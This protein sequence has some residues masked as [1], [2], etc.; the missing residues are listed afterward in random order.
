MFVGLI[1]GKPGRYAYIYDS[2]ILDYI[3]KR[4]P[5]TTRVLG[6]LFKKSGYG[7]AFRKNSP[8]VEMFDN[9]ILELRESGMMETI[10]RQWIT[11][12]CPNSESG[13]CKSI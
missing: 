12:S 2:T 4:Q 10:E 8:Y 9:A 5:C 3:T 11:G 13:E 7:I 1:S 6:H